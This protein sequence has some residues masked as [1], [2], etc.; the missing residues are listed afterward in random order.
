MTWSRCQVES[1]SHVDL[2]VG[3][4]VDV[5]SGDI[6]V[7]TFYYDHAMQLSCEPKFRGACLVTK[8]RIT[9]G[10]NVKRKYR[11]FGF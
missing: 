8:V 7:D 9:R 2:V 1:P 11:N 5:C 6:D 3:G 4:D 10:S